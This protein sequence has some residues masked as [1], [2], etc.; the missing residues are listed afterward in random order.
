MTP[1]GPQS[2]TNYGCDMA[3]S[4]IQ[5]VLDHYGITSFQ[6]QGDLGSLESWLGSGRDVIL[7]VDGDRIWNDLPGGHEG[8]QANHAVVLTGID[9]KT[10]MAY[11]NDPG[12]KGGKEEVV[13]ISELMAAWQ[14][15]DYT[16]VVTEDQPTVHELTDTPTPPA[17]TNIDGA[18]TTSTEPAPSI[19]STARALAS[20]GG[21]VI[22]PALM[23]HELVRAED[24]IEHRIHDVESA[25]KDIESNF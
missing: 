6:V 2:S 3:P 12:T 15:S 25:A 14:T 4:Q 21:P 13:P 8:N 9:L 17:A 22:L 24:D 23:H 19:D 20:S 5:T 18:V 11:L 16:A 1:Q 10:G 7:A